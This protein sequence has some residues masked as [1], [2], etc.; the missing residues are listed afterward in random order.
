M[1]SFAATDSTNTTT[2]LGSTD[3]DSVHVVAVRWVLPCALFD[4]NDFVARGSARRDGQTGRAHAR[5]ASGTVRGRSGVHRVR[6]RAR[7]EATDRPA[8]SRS[9]G[10]SWIT[11][12]GRRVPHC[13][14]VPRGSRR[15]GVR[16]G[17]RVA[18]GVHS[19]PSRRR[20]GV[21]ARQRRCVPDPNASRVSVDAPSRAFPFRPAA[22]V[23]STL[24]TTRARPS[25]PSPTT[26]WLRRRLRP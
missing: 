15:D 20:S 3:E 18:P 12:F 16:V 5:G 19:R 24:T 25:L 1:T 10:R 2:S 4:S 7:L 26:R 21:S 9:D 14:R 6:R 23:R 22:S 13:R 8:A 17:P 11:D